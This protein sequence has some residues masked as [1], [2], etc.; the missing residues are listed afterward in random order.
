MFCKL[1]HQ[2]RESCSFICSWGRFAA[3]GG[4]LSP[5]SLEC[6]MERRHQSSCMYSLF[7]LV[8]CEQV[9]KTMLA[10]CDA[11][12]WA[13]ACSKSRGLHYS[14]YFY[15]FLRI[16]WC[17]WRAMKE[18]ITFAR[19]LFYFRD[20]FSFL[21]LKYKYMKH[22]FSYLCMFSKEGAGMRSNVTERK[23]SLAHTYTFTQNEMNRQ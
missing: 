22:M 4:N 15:F 16:F 14:N 17:G 23:I 7:L 8:Y 10:G 6:F 9:C 12:T 1:P 18:I 2:H 11:S 19:H 3:F 13:A 5:L 20:S 21:R